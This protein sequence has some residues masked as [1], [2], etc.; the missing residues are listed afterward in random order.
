MALMT[1]FSA[2]VGVLAL[3]G[4]LHAQIPQRYN[5]GRGRIES[6]INET[7]PRPVFAAMFDDSPVLG[8]LYVLTPLLFLAACRW[9]VLRLPAA[10]AAASTICA[11][12][13]TKAD[14]YWQ[15]LPQDPAPLALGI[16]Y[17]VPGALLVAALLL[18]P[19]T[20]ADAPRCP[21]PAPAG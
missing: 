12:L 19:G 5:T 10:A 6:I 2:G 7:E 11:M 15:T 17:L 4:W 13:V 18:P 9:R 8:G 16:W 21:A 20:D 14:G 1:A 3:T